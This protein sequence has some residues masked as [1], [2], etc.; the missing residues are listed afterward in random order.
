[1]SY[2]KHEASKNKRNR[3]IY[4]GSFIYDILFNFNHTVLI[5]YLY[6][7]MLYMYKY[8][9]EICVYPEL[10]CQIRGWQV[11]KTCNPSMNLEMYWLLKLINFVEFFHCIMYWIYIFN[12]MFQGQEWPPKQMM[13]K[14]QKVN[15]FSY[16]TA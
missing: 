7:Y 2:S 12:T 14:A 10:K 11:T 4:T 8:A 9:S 6:I 1:M 15:E 3:Y 16:D 13:E 5:L